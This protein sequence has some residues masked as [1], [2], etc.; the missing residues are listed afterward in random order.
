MLGE[1]EGKPVRE[2]RR[3][4]TGESV[5]LPVREREEGL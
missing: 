1:E 4:R 2:G 5:A 3:G